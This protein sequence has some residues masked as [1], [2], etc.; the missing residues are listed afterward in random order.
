MELLFY[1]AQS[2]VFAIFVLFLLLLNLQGSLMMSLTANLE[3]KEENLVGNN[4]WEVV[5]NYKKTK[6]ENEA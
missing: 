1:H 4:D 2:P 6:L 3:Q 5:K